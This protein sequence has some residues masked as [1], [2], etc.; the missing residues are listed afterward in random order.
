MS[1]RESVLLFRPVDGKSV[2]IVRQGNGAGHRRDYNSS[3]S[4]T[5]FPNENP[6]TCFKITSALCPFVGFRRAC[7]FRKHR[8]IVH[9]SLHSKILKSRH[10]PFAYLRL[11]STDFVALVQL[12]Y[13]RPLSLILCKTVFLVVIYLCTEW[14]FKKNFFYHK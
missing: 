10:V 1:V 4:G 12:R 2:I 11:H 9:L 5:I 14:F 8:C 7:L 13:E 3:R 6:T